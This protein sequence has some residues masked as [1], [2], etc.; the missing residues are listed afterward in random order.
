MALFCIYAIIQKL[1]ADHQ[2]E[3]SVYFQLQA[4]EQQKKAQQQ[5]KLVNDMAKEID[6]LKE[7]I[8]NC[9]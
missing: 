3:K 8:K 4:E 2:K 5:R 6:K 1:E 7:E 9:R